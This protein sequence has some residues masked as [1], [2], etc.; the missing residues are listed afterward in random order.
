MIDSYGKQYATALDIKEAC[1]DANRLDLP[2]V[3][4]DEIDLFVARYDKNNDRRIKFSEFVY[5]FAPV[6]PYLCEKAN[7]RKSYGLKFQEKTLLMYRNLWVHQFK[8]EQQAE[9]I[10]QKLHKSSTFS[11]YDA[12]KAV[13]SNEDNRIT[14]DE[15]RKIIE[16][17]SKG[18]FFVTSQEINQ[19]MERYDK[20]GDGV[21]SYS[22]FAD[23]IRPHSPGKKKHF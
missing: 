21:I 8:T 15:L 3:T 6:D 19:L 20:N 9:L 17:G 14:R 23:E 1:D 10:R 22:E 12:F 13:D 16:E 5:A 7:Q 4:M 2:H 11:V 18:G